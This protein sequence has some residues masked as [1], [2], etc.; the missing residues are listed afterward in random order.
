MI[1]LL[2]TTIEQSIRIP[3][4]YSRHDGQ[5]TLILTSTIDKRVVYSSLITDTGSSNIYLYGRISLPEGLADGEYT[6]EVKIG[7]VTLSKGLATIGE[8]SE[9]TFF[10][11]ETFIEYEQY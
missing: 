2:N 7:D 9:P 1:N 3:Y 4:V 5:K 11:N 10:E 8:Y 6:Y